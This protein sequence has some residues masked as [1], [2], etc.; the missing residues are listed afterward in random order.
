[1]IKLTIEQVNNILDQENDE[2]LWKLIYEFKND[3][4]LNLPDEEIDHL[5]TRLKTTYCYLLELGFSKELL[6]D[7]FLCAEATTPGI[8]DN[9]N[10]KA[11]IEKPGENPEIQFEDLLR[12]GIKIQQNN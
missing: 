7:A 11:W 8:K 3:S 12:I 4:R 10:F 1:M 9:Q 2:Y 6:I 5:F